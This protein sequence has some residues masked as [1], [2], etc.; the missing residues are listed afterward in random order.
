MA[1]EPSNKPAV[2]GM[3]PGGPVPA[4]KPP[5]AAPAKEAY[6]GLRVSLMPSEIEGGA[7]PDL[8]RGALIL[9]LVLIFETII[10]G[11]VNFWLMQNTAKRVAERDQLNQRI[12]AV[13]KIVTDQG[14]EMSAVIDLDRQIQTTL[15]NLGQ[16]VYWTKFFRFLEDNARPNVR[17][18]RFSGDVD[19][20]MFSIDILGKSYRDVA[21]QIVV[22][23]E[24]PMTLN[25]RATSASARIGQAGEV[26]GVA[27]SLVIKIKP[28]VWRQAAVAA[29]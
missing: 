2:G 16:H 18:M 6:A 11:G 12:T 1:L 20:G 22:L 21:E 7:A 26:D 23:R 25:V 9:F 3:P 17:F 28:E 14:K 8:R 29:Q 4:A 13:N 5:G 24:N 19:S 27:S 15:D 10:I